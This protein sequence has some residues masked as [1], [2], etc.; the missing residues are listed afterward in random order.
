MPR[1]SAQTFGIKLIAY[2][3]DSVVANLKL[4]M[5]SGDFRGVSG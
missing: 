2:S 1:Y 4:V 3:R 5:I